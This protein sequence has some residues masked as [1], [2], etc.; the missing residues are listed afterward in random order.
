M[1]NNNLRDNNKIKVNIITPFLNNEFTRQ[2]PANI[3]DYIFVEN[4]DNEAYYDFIVVYEG[5]KSET[6]ICCPKGNLLFISGEPP[7]SMV[8]TKEFISQFDSIITSHPKIKH[9]Q[10]I[11]SQQSLPWHFGYDYLT[12]RYKYNFSDLEN[13]KIPQKEKKI[14]V[15]ASGKTMMPGHKKRVEFIAELKKNFSS[16]IDFFGKDSNFVADKA[17]AILPYKM[18]ICI[19]NCSIA[20]YWTEKIADPFLG[21]SMPIYYGCTNINDYFNSES[22]VPLDINDISKSILKV[23][24]LLLNCESIYK[25]AMPAIIESRD[26]ILKKYNIFPLIIDFIESKNIQKNKISTV[27]SLY[28]NNSFLS[29]KFELLKLRIERYTKKIIT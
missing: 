3:C 23:N 17:D 11:L 12:K 20:N 21:F 15:I 8:Y 6:K 28:P 24:H 9:K 26:L 7:I 16:E 2:L 1:Y 29:F 18:N 10:K 14:S 13:L 19:E 25:E 22:F 27:Q 4:G 5:L